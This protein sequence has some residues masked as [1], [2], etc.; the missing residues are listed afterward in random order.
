MISKRITY[1]ICPFCKIGNAYVYK[2][3][4][5]AI[6]MFYCV[7]FSCGLKINYVDAKHIYV[8]QNCSAGQSFLTNKNRNNI[9]RIVKNYEVQNEQ[10]RI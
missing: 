10:A 3:S 4:S 8:W 7:D 1:N 9:E 6:K 5:I 2:G